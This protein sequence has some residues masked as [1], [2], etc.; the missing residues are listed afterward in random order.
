MNPDG[1]VYGME[2]DALISERQQ[3]LSLLT[4]YR[5]ETQDL[6]DL[7]ADETAGWV[8]QI[9]AWCRDMAAEFWEWLRATIGP[10]PTDSIHVNWQ[11]I[12]QGVFCL[13]IALLTFWLTRHLIKKWRRL[14]QNRQHTLPGLTP[15]HHVSREAARL[16]RQL[17]AA[18]TTADWARATR[19][20]WCL[21]L[22]DMGYPLHLT[23]REC[24]REMQS[25]TLW[26]QYQGTPIHDLYR[27][28]FAAS[29]G[30]RQWFE[31]YQNALSRIEGQRP[32][33]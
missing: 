31:H 1:Y 27:V 8:Q 29:S 4:Q 12:I 22:H 26:E 33:G 15:R 20:R 2:S 30:S 5:E 6:P 10:L 24:F 11:A 23:P 21:F 25:L 16:G 17:S 28:M 19:L 7:K 14:D 9:Q 32:N 3:L 18:L 13:C